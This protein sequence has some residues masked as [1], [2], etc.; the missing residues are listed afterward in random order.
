M[1]KIDFTKMVASGNDFIVLNGL[2]TNNIPQGK[3]LKALVTD[4]CS[5]RYSVGADGVLLLERSRNAD[6]KMRI[7][8]PDGS[9]VDM[10]GNGIRCAALLASGQKSSKKKI[11]IDTRA[12][13][14]KA[15]I[16]GNRV[17]VELPDPKDLRLNIKL[18]IDGTPYTAHFINTGVQHTVFFVKNVDRVDVNRLGSKTRFHRRFAPLGTNANFV[19][20]HNSRNIS[21]RTYERG[22]EDETFAC[23][24]GSVASAIISALLKRTKSPVRVQ[25][26]GNN[27][28][29]I[30]FDIEK[31]NV[32]RNVYLEGDAKIVYRG[33]MSYV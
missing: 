2:G 5:R 27:L 7:L 4:I 28:L 12:G 22:V 15:I 8:N 14:H 23:G 19:R 9:E 24:T 18:N 25:T 6:L 11:T 10:C 13:I 20:V 33:G 32:V 21:V 26:K 30:Y 3:K 1:R 17:K 29:K 31:H 16:K